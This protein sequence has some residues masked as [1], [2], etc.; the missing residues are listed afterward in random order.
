MDEEYIEMCKKA[1]EIQKI[2]RNKDLTAEACLDKCGRFCWNKSRS[3]DCLYEGEPDVNDCFWLPFQEDLQEIYKTDKMMIDCEMF[4]KFMQW[5]F[6]FTCRKVNYLTGEVTPKFGYS[7]RAGVGD[8]AQALPKSI[9]TLNELWLE[10]VMEK[11]F[12]KAWNCETKSWEA[13]EP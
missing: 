5:M 12:N 7:Y 4:E 9:S 6:N 11:C 8:E 2:W 13:I 10:F 3:I 1:E